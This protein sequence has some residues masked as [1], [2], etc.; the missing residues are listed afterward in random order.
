LSQE[1]VQSVYPRATI[2]EFEQV[3]G[4]YILDRFLTEELFECIWLSSLCQDENTAWE[5]AWENAKLQIFQ[6]L[7]L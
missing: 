2:Y 7:I 6:K 3:Y 4:V 5:N 1:L